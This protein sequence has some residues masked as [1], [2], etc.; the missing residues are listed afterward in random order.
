LSIT[1]SEGR[2]MDI[3]L[4][5]VPAV[6]AGIQIVGRRGVRMRKL[7]VGLVLAALAL[8]VVAIGAAQ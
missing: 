7:L 6:R 3:L 2:D 1:F 8:V 5:A 4:A